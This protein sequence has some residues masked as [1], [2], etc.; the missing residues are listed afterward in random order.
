MAKRPAVTELETLADFRAY[1]EAHPR[2]KQ[3]TYVL[4][5]LDR[6]DWLLRQ[7]EAR[8]TEGAD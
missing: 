1:V 7:A 4:V 6:L 5:P 8:A 2:I 3:R